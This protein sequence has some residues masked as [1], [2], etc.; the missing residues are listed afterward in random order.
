MKKIFINCTTKKLTKKQLSTV[1]E[2]GEIEIIELKDTN[3]SIKKNVL[4]LR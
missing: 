2:F 3:L 4:N 1:Q